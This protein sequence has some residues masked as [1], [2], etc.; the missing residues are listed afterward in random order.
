MTTIG[1]QY[2]YCCRDTEYRVYKTT[3]SV[4]DNDT[5]VL[6]RNYTICDLDLDYDGNPFVSL[7]KETTCTE[8]AREVFRQCDYRLTHT[9]C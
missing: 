4:T 3:T 5:L 6:L 1:L 2:V 7:L 9:M 8:C